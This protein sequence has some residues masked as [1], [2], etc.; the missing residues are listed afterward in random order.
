[1]TGHFFRGGDRGG[2]QACFEAPLFYALADT[3][4]FACKGI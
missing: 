2:G 1:M 3:I 4:F